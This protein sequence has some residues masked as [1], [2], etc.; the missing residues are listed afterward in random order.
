MSG[1]DFWHPVLKT[2][3]VERECVKGVKLA[4]QSFAVFPRP[5]DN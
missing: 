3:D 2:G 4:G 1:L 5:T